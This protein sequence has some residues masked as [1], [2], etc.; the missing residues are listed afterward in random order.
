MRPEAQKRNNW[1]KVL[2]TLW[3]RTGRGW[4]QRS[5]GDQPQSI[6]E[7]SLGCPF[8]RARGQSLVSIA[9]FQQLE[10]AKQLSVARPL[11]HLYAYL[12]ASNFLVPMQIP[13]SVPPGCNQPE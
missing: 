8:F 7:R 11:G 13:A 12:L 3:Y 9:K 2:T 1:T 10:F 6:V 5:G 4:S